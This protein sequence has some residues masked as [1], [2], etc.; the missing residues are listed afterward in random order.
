MINRLSA[1]QLEKMMKQIGVKTEE[2]P[3]KKV[4]IEGENEIYEIL[5][6]KISKISFQG[7]DTIQIQG[8][9]RKI[10]RISEE[11][12]QLIMEKT[13]VSREIAEKTLREVN[14]ISEAIIRLKSECSE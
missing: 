10:E 14:D 8:E 11:D 1:R 6:P 2:I 5:N 7:N 12:I 3:A 13:G 4:V 9:I